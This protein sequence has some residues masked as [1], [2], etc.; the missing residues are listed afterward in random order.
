MGLTSFSLH[1]SVQKSEDRCFVPCFKSPGEEIDN[2]R[3]F[4]SGGCTVHVGCTC[5]PGCTVRVGSP[6]KKV[7]SRSIKDLMPVSIT[8][9]KKQSMD[10][11]GLSSSVFEKCYFGGY[12]QIF[13]TCDKT[14]AVQL[15]SAGWLR[16][17]SGG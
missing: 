16:T 2:L 8:D 7:A 4:N 10:I 1:R 5:S 3:C 14:A 11:D 9:S 6:R 15:K 17:R 12:T 13:G